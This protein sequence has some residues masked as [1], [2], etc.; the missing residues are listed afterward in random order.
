M[1]CELV[2]LYSEEGNLDPSL[3]GCLDL[4]SQKAYLWLF[5]CICCLPFPSLIFSTVGSRKWCRLDGNRFL[6]SSGCSVPAVP[7]PFFHLSL[8]QI[9]DCVAHVFSICPSLISVSHI[10]ISFLVWS[11][12]K[13]IFKEYGINHIKAVL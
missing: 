6:V 8:L 1:S 9:Q 4:K 3:Q 10:F 7:C 11:A 2:Y 12:V 13:T 5:S